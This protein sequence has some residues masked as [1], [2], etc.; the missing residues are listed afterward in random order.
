MCLGGF[1][2]YLL[3]GYKFARNADEIQRV[4]FLGKLYKVLHHDDP[5]FDKAEELDSYKNMVM[6]KLN[7]KY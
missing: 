1:I 4:E 6:T 2:G 3:T 7:Q 5:I